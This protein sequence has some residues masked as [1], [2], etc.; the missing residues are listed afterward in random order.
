GVAVPAGAGNLPRLTSPVRL[1][2]GLEGRSGS[3]IGAPLTLSAA[4]SPPTG[5]V[6]VSPAPPVRSAAVRSSSAPIPLGAPDSAVAVAGAVAAAAKGAS[7]PRGFPTPTSPPLPEPREG[8]ALARAS[9]ARSASGRKGD[10]SS[11]R[12]LSHPE[13]P[14]AGGGL[15]PGEAAVVAAGQQPPARDSPSLPAHLPLES[16]SW[17]TAGSPAAAAAAAVVQAKPTAEPIPRATSF[18]SN[19]SNAASAL[20]QKVLGMVRTSSGPSI[21]GGMEHG[22]GA[23]V[24]ASAGAA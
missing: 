6:P 15:S 16:D 23:T 4:S 17:A 10:D 19:F 14:W 18:L 22:G 7:V 5:S 3:G 11:S 1:Q 13:A 24:S 12:R 21:P 8:S 2:L 9:P 20:E